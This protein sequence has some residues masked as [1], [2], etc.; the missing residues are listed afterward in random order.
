LWDWTLDSDYDGI[1][2]DKASQGATVTLTITDSPITK[3]LDNVTVT[4]T[5]LKELAEDTT[6]TDMDFKI[7]TALQDQADGTGTPTSAMGKNEIQFTMP[8]ND[9]YVHITL[10]PTEIADTTVDLGK[11][12][13]STGEWTV[14]T[15]TQTA[16]SGPYKDPVNEDDNL[17][18]PYYYKVFTKMDGA[19]P[20]FSAEPITSPVT[21]QDTP[22]T[23]LV[24]TPTGG[25]EL[26]GY[27]GT[28]EWKKLNTSAVGTPTWED[29]AST[30]PFD[31]RTVY[32][33]IVTINVEDG[34]VI[35]STPLWAHANSFKSVT[36]VDTRV[37]TEGTAVTVNS[38]TIAGNDALLT[39][40]TDGIKYQAGTPALNGGI[41]EIVFKPFIPRGDDVDGVGANL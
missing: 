17:P 29:F 14:T 37:W 2:T 40:F 1:K 25:N 8:P 36:G 21:I 5:L 32:K 18:S 28:V 24:K 12:T 41:L 16:G 9:V 20:L 30:Q 34:Y 27:S 35:A 23:V 15:Y 6:G 7:K 33:A 26:T 13:R 31:P 4:V 22:K 38:K 11:A 39:G 3:S 10:T 19:Q